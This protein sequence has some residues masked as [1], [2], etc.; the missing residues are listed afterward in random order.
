MKWE[1]QVWEVNLEDQPAM[2]YSINGKSRE[3]RFYRR[4][5]RAEREGWELVAVDGRHMFFKR[6]LVEA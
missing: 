3:G 4:L 6:P 2:L 5:A 1:H